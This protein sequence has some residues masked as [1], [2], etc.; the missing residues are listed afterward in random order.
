MVVA[1]LPAMPMQSSALPPALQRS[2]PHRARKVIAAGVDAVTLPL[3]ADWTTIEHVSGGAGASGAVGYWLY[4]AIRAEI[5]GVALQVSQHIENDRATFV[6]HAQRLD[7]L[8]RN[9]LRL[10][11]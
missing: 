7:T 10:P 3:V 6:D 5:R 8:T 4:R 2:W 9:Q 11:P 1:A